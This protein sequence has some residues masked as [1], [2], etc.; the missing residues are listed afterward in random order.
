MKFKVGQRVAVYNNTQRRTGEIES[1]YSTGNL[2]IQLNEIDYVWVVHP[3]HC[4]RLRKK[5]RRVVWITARKIKG[6]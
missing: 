1:I 4:R 5:K 3:K 2:R 6:L